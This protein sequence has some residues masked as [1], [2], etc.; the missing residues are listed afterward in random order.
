MIKSLDLIMRFYYT[1]RSDTK[2]QRDLG[3]MSSKKTE[4]KKMI[5]LEKFVLKG[6]DRNKK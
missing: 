4:K 3:I 5:T 1:H 2:L 6:N